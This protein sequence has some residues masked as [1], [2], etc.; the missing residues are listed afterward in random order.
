MKNRYRI[1]KAAIIALCVSAAGVC[2]SCSLQ[3]GKW[4]SDSLT[5]SAKKE[6]GV[7]DSAKEDSLKKDS[8]IPSPQQTKEETAGESF[9]QPPSDEETDRK[10]TASAAISLQETASAAEEEMSVC[11]V[12]ICG[13]INSP[14][15]YEMEEGSRIYQIV[16]RAGGFTEK[17][18]S[19]YLNMAQTV[20]DGMKIVVPDQSS[21]K[22]NRFGLDD[23]GREGG[24]GSCIILPERA[25]S[26]GGGS[27]GAAAIRE[28][29]N[30]NTA[31]KEELMTLKGVGEARALDIIAYRDSRGGFRK[32]ED[33]MKISGIKNSAFEKIKNDIT[34]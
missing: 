1:V 20:C 9:S 26:N 33:I 17:A 5:E 6:P 32:I 8:P 12:H 15:V 29:V 18:A 11:C 30:I 25:D 31:A 4:S 19:Q 7:K 16:E 24:A 28:K 2:Y 21:L 23:A 3:A 34:V 22:A 10:P 13:E 27:N 14:G